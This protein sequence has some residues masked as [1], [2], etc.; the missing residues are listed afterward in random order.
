MACRQARVAYSRRYC[1]LHLQRLGW[2]NWYLPGAPPLLYR[3]RRARAAN[4]ASAAVVE[5][6]RRGVAGAVACQ[7]VR[8]V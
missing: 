2:H 8:V 5:E 3:H 6:L 7:W 4:R 1:S